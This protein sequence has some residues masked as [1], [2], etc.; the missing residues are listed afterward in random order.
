MLATSV[1]LADTPEQLGVGQAQNPAFGLLGTD[2]LGRPHRL[3]PQLAPVP[4]VRH[5][6]AARLEADAAAD[7]GRRHVLR[8]ELR[9]VV[10]QLFWRRLDVRKLQ[11]W[12]LPSRER[13]HGARRIPTKQPSPRSLWRKV[14]L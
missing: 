7:P 10:L 1:L 4:Q 6:L 12:I 11:H 9:V 8:A 13:W 3:R 5:G 2:E 14:N